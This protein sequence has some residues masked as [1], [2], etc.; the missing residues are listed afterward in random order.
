MLQLDT[1][2]QTYGLHIANI[3]YQLDLLIASYGYYML[4]ECDC[5]LL[6]TYCIG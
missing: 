1:S 6:L 4:T 3:W 2:N 5:M